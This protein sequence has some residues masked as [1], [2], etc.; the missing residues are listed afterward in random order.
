MTHKFTPL[1]RCHETTLYVWEKQVVRG[2]TKV[3]KLR[4]VF[5]F[6]VDKFREARANACIVHDL[7]IRRWALKHRAEIAFHGFKASDTWILN[8]KKKLNVVSRKITKFVTAATAVD[9]DEQIN[10]LANHFVTC[11]EMFKPY[12]AANIWNSDQTGFKKEMHTGRT[13]NTK[14]EKHI[15]GKVQSISAGTHSLT[16]QPLMSMSGVL[17]PKLFIMF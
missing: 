14:G 10:V 16:A 5:N 4:F 17:A 1:S 6:V 9:K 12:S 3:D 2:G 11:N 8:F 7:D 13:L 15:A